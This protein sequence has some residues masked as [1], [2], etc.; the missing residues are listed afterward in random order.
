V[1]AF[2]KTTTQGYYGVEIKEDKPGQPKAA[3]AGFAVNLAP[4]ESLFTQPSEEDIRGWL[5]GAELTFVDASG[6]AQQEFGS[7]GQGHEIWRTLIGI[8]F[9]VI[10]VEFFLATL[11]GKRSEFGG[12]GSPGSHQ[13]RSQ[14]GAWIGRMTGAHELRESE[15]TMSGTQGASQ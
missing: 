3:T 5:P 2:E 7:I 13:G 14:P 11:S 12:D 8:T 10:A 6:E 4:D 9:L 15:S 1:G